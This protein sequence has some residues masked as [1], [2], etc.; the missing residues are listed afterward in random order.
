MGKR[1][2]IGLTAPLT[3]LID[4]QIRAMANGKN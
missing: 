1:L 4:E 2:F 3:A